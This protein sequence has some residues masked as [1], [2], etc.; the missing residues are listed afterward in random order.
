VPHCSKVFIL[1]RNVTN[2]SYMHF[3]SNFIFHSSLHCT[4]LLSPPIHSMLIM[5]LHKKCP[6]ITQAC[7][8][9]NWYIFGAPL[10][11]PP[12]QGAL[13]PVL[14]GVE[15]YCDWGKL[16]QTCLSAPA[17]SR[18]TCQAMHQYTSRV[19]NINSNAKLQ[20]MDMATV[21]NFQV[22]MKRPWQNI[23]FPFRAKCMIETI[24]SGTDL[25]TTLKFTKSLPIS[26]QL[27]V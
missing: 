9:V 17:A 19:K 2:A 8:R 5:S 16:Q 4:N 22:F 15:L 13:T 7:N 1:P 6:H 21:P 24:I 18:A 3:S 25:Y 11:R 26:K 12:W 10:R 20:Y 23:K 14:A 27:S